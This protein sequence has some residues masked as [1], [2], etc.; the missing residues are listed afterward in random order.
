MTTNQN[1]QNI[2]FR[3]L[4]D[5]NA[6][7]AFMSNV[8]KNNQEGYLKDFFIECNPKSWLSLPFVWARTVQGN[9]FWFNLS[10]KWAHVIVN[11]DKKKQK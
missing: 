6:Y 10:C 5:N 8:E 7:L 4:K 3:F 2:F 11:I 9:K 1:I